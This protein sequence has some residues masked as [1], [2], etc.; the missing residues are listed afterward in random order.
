MSRSSRNSTVGNR[1]SPTSTRRALFGLVVPPIAT[2]SS[3]SST[4]VY[5]RYLFGNALN[6]S[7]FVELAELST[8]SSNRWPTS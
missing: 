6:P 3:S 2:S 7:R 8:R 4:D 5:Q 1:A